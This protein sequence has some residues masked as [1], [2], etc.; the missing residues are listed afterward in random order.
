MSKRLLAFA[1][2]FAAGSLVAS[3]KDISGR[4]KAEGIDPEGTRFRKRP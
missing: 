2:F 1:F 4:Y 3:A